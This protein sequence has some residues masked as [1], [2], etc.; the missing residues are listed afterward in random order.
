MEVSASPLW[1]RNSP[2]AQKL[3]RMCNE[4]SFRQPCEADSKIGSCRISR[5]KCMDTSPLSSSGN[6]LS[7]W[8]KNYRLKWAKWLSG[9]AGVV[10]FRAHTAEKRSNYLVY[11]DTMV[12]RPH[13]L[14]VILHPVL[15]LTGYLVQC[16]EVLEVSPL[17]LV[18][19]PPGVHA[20]DD[21]R[22]VTEHYGV[23]ERYTR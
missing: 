8:N 3:L 15:Q 2:G 12:E 4:S 7:V 17:A 16:Q 20:L 5:C 6:S 21:G 22:H 19:R 1:M 11:V 10:D 23:H 18:Q 13:G 9:C 14:K